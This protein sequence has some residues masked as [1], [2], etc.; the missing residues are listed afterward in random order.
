MDLLILFNKPTTNRQTR[1]Q[2]SRTGHWPVVFHRRPQDD[3][4]HRRDLA[5]CAETLYETRPERCFPPSHRFSPPLALA[6]RRCCS[7]LAASAASGLPPLPP[8][9]G[10]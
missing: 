2:E 3:T 4:R 9:I 7:L 5:L 8:L 1:Q 6:C 10:L